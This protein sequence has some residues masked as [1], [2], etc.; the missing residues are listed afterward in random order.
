MGRL[1]DLVVVNIG[2]SFTYTCSIVLQLDRVGQS[3]PGIDQRLQPVRRERRVV[4]GDLR[5]HRRSQPEPEHLR[6]P[7]AERVVDE[8]LRRFVDGQICAGI[9]LEWVL[10]LTLDMVV[11]GSIP[12]TANRFP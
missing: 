3:R 2:L 11:T 5:R 9:L 6:D 10:A 4:V 7:A 8:G 1:S 12:A